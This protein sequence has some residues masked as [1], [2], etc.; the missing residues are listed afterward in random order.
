M[1]PFHRIKGAGRHLRRVRLRQAEGVAG[2]RASLG[3]QNQALCHFRK[4]VVAHS[5]VAPA[6]RALLALTLCEQPTVLSPPDVL[7]LLANDRP[8]VASAEEHIQ[9]TY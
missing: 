8:H 6:Q 9:P 1:S 3:P 4:Q 2:W 7:P 5:A